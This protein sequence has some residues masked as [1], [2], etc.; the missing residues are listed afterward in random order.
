MTCKLMFFHIKDIITIKANQQKI[1]QLK[2]KKTK[3]NKTITPPTCAYL[4]L[5]DGNKDSVIALTEQDYKGRF[6]RMYV[7]QPDISKIELI[8]LSCSSDSAK[9]C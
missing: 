1:T 8:C 5:F 2:L 9:R 7:V 6:K 4:A 3:E